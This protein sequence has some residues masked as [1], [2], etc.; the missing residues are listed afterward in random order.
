[1]YEG[2]VERSSVKKVATV[3]NVSETMYELRVDTNMAANGMWRTLEAGRGVPAG[4]VCLR[5]GGEGAERP[6]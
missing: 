6:H 2:P 1:M 4:I 3:H 5:R